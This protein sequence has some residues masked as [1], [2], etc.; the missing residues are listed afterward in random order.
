MTTDSGGRTQ[1]RP[2]AKTNRHCAA[3]VQTL[4]AEQAS[5]VSFDD[6]TYQ[7]TKYDVPGV[8]FLII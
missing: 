5:V 8:V 7:S 4:K 2:V 6:C 3:S 1:G